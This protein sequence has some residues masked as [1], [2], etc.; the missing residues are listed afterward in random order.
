M[1]ELPTQHNTDETR[2]LLLWS[3]NGYGC[4]CFLCFVF[5]CVIMGFCVLFLFCEMVMAAICFVLKTV[6]F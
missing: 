4:F 6:L 1:V 3:T 2:L 5:C